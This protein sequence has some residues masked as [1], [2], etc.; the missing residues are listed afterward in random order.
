HYLNR[1]Q[2]IAITRCRIRHSFATHSFLISKI[3][4]PFVMNVT[5]TF[6]FI[7]SSSKFAQSTETCE[8]TSL[9]HRIWKKFSINK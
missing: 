3:L 2:E 4:H 5:Q 8:T 1:R 7:T 6:Q 9:Y